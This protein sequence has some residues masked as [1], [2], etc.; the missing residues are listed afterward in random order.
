MQAKT[1]KDEGKPEPPEAET[2]F[3]RLKDL[4][5]KHQNEDV[6]NPWSNAVEQYGSALVKVGGP[7]GK[8]VSDALNA[9]TCELDMKRNYMINS[10]KFQARSYKS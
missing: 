6:P 7:G 3:G 2:E 5:E 10:P 1:L 8:M 9:N 4:R